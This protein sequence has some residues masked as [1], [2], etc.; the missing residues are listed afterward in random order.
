MPQVLRAQWGAPVAPSTQSRLFKGDKTENKVLN[1]PFDPGVP[2]PTQALGGP[3]QCAEGYWP[4]EVT[5]TQ[6][7]LSRLF[8]F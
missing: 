5:H 3:D 6:L 2:S 8:F 4:L 7:F 1:C